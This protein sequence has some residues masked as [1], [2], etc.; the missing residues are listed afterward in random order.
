MTTI[1][2]TSIQASGLLIVGLTFVGFVAIVPLTMF[3]ISRIIYC[4]YK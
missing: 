3:T 4:F 2:K 1:K